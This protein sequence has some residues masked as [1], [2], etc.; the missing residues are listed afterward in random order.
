MDTFISLG[1]EIRKVALP[2]CLL[3]F[4]IT[5]LSQ[6]YLD[7]CVTEDQEDPQGIYSYSTDPEDLEGLDPVVFN[8]YYWRVDDQNGNPNPVEHLTEEKALES[9]QYFNIGFNPIGI[10]FKYRGMGTITSPSNLEWEQKNYEEDCCANFPFDNVDPCGNEVTTVDPDGFSNISQCQLTE[11]SSFVNNNGYKVPNAINIYVTLT[12]D[13]GGVRSADY[14]LTHPTGISGTTGIH[15]LGHFFGLSHTFLNWIKFNQDGT[16]NESYENCEHVTRDPN[17]P[18]YNADSRGDWVTDTAAMPSFRREHCFLENLPL[19]QCSEGGPYFFEYYDR[20]N[21]KYIGNDGQNDRRDCQGTP[22]DINETQSRNYMSYAPGSC[23]DNFT[24]GQMVKMRE[25]I[26]NSITLQGKTTTLASLYEPYKGEYYVGG[27]VVP[28]AQNPPLFQ[29]GFNYRFLECDCDPSCPE[30]SPYGD[31]SFS[32]GNNSLLTVFD[33]ETDFSTITHPNHTAIQI[34]F[35]YDLPD[36]YGQNVRRCYDNW[37]RAAINGSLTQFNDGVFNGNVT[38]TQQDSTQIN[39][40]NL[41]NELGP[42]LYK[43][44]KNYDDG[45]SKETVVLKEQNE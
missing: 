35:V 34:D 10:Y 1:R 4:S 41:V 39:N 8:V 15:E 20:P 23:L 11:F 13:F 21:C 27:P 9:I 19:S 32:Y 43:V 25:T 36:N 3:F 33:D 26:D 17:D 44:G 37:N 5:L 45:T 42:G 30:P 24:V 29:P 7:I 38:V 28:S 40:P 16:V 31:V 22:Y 6:D 14:I 12:T 18:A 2:I